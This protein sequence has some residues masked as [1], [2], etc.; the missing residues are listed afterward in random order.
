VSAMRSDAARI[1][2]TA[3]LVYACG[4]LGAPSGFAPVEVAT[5]AS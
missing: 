5:C 4:D 3:L 1:F 2:V